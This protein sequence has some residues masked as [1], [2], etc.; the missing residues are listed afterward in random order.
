MLGRL[1]THP[2]ARGHRAGELNWNIDLVDGY[3]GFEVMNFQTARHW[4][5]SGIYNLFVINGNI[6][7]DIQDHIHQLWEDL[8]GEERVF[9][10]DWHYLC[11]EQNI[12]FL[13]SFL[14]KSSA[15][16]L[17]IWTIHTYSI[18]HS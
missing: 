1:C 14:N 6:H 16:V 10:E 9:C 13:I 8:L 18:I 4:L 5:L 15:R 11:P 12:L 2:Q 7:K 3:D 17:E